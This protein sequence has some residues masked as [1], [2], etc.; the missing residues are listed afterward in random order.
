MKKGDIIELR[1]IDKHGMISF[2]HATIKNAKAAKKLL[3]EKNYHEMP[4]EPGC[5]FCSH[6]YDR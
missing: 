6:Q 1:T 3:A 5:Y 2:Q 4:A